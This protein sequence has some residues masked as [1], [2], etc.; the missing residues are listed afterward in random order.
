MT[1]SLMRRWDDHQ[2]QLR[3]DE[4]GRCYDAADLKQTAE[5]TFKRCHVRTTA[6]TSA[7]ARQ[8]QYMRDK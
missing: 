5:E 4:I 2:L 8:G 3:L 7:T 6:S 1:V